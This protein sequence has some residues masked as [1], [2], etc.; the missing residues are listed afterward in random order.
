M[1]KILNN[2]FFRNLNLI[3]HAWT[4][5]SGIMKSSAYTNPTRNLLSIKETKMLEFYGIFPV[6]VSLIVLKLC[7]SIYRWRNPECKGR[8]P[9]GSMHLRDFWYMGF[10]TIGETFEF[11]T[12]YDFSSVVSPYLKK[13]ISRLLTSFF[14]FTFLA[15]RYASYQTI[16]C[17]T[18]GACLSS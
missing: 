6:V 4:A 9:P 11:M 18:N 7:H 8:L 13:R 1:W 5:D 15:I 12:P 17:F 14:L 10:P 16:T 3:L 2:N